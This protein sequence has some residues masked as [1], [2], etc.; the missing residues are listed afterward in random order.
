MIE[1]ILLEVKDKV[2]PDLVKET[3]LDSEKTNAAIDIINEAVFDEANHY[4]DKGNLLQLKSVFENSSNEEKMALFNEF[5]DKVNQKLFDELQ[6][7][8]DAAGKIF[9]RTTPELM[10]SARFKV[11][12]PKG[13]FK[14]TDVPKI[15]GFVK[16]RGKNAKA[17]G[18]GGMFGSIFG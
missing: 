8:A 12:G 4:L 9:D 1:E 2:T 5:K 7:E 6:I 11:L 14:I 17:G 10:Q 16:S 18:L 15:I 3:G 13:D